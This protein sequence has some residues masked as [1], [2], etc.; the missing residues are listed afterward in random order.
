MEVK[1]IV[2][3]A[4]FNNISVKSQRS[5]SL[6]EKTMTTMTAPPCNLIIIIIIIIIIKVLVLLAKVALADC[7]CPVW[8]LWFTCSHKLFEYVTLQSFECGRV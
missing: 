6:V 8:N 4:T 5:V 7:A 3:N 1:V 2:L